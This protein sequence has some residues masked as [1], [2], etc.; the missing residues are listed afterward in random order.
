MKHWIHVPMK[1][2]MLI[3]IIASLNESIN[4]DNHEDPMVMESHSIRESISEMNVELNQD[5]SVSEETSVNDTTE[6]SSEGIDYSIDEDYFV[7]YQENVIFGA[8][9]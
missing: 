1:V 8:V 3:K 7:S 9:S 5:N 6:E 4:N 2:I